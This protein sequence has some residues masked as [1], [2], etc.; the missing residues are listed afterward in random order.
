MQKKS[1]VMAALAIGAIAITI[2]AGAARCSLAPEETPVPEEQA[3]QQEVVEDRE[4]GEGAEALAQGGFADLKNT[5]WESEDGKSTLSI[6]EGAF[7]EKGEAGSTILYYTVDSEDVSDKEMTVTLS[8][9]TSMTG[10]EEQTVAVVRDVGGEREIVCDK[11]ACKYTLSAPVDADMA[12]S[13]ATDELYD[14]F[15]KSEGD[16]K[17][18]IGDYAK[19]RSPHA[20]KA[21]WSGEV[22]I[23]FNAG[24]YLTNFTLDDAASTIV[25]VQMDGS[26]KLAT[27]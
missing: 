9:S 16:F 25:T 27:L 4:G 6:I 24:S 18:V 3:V 1:K 7:V 17:Q 19:E 20:K 14:L 2:G 26:G 23:D 5:N 15:G 12:V 22:W 21:A 11:L 8:A 13:G 10:D